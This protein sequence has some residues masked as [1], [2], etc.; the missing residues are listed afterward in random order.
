[1]PARRISAPRAGAAAAAAAAA[2]AIAATAAVRP[3]R[4]GRPG[5]PGRPGRA[6]K[7][8]GTPSTGATF[9]E[10]AAAFGAWLEA[11]AA[12]ATELLVG[13]HK[14]GTGRPSLTWSESVDEALCVGW[15]DGVR[16]RIDE[17]AYSIRF[18]PR[19]PGSI[20]S[21]I[22]TAK[23]EQLRAQGRM[24]PAGERAFAQRTVARSVVYA[25]EQDA[26]AGF[27]A[28]ELRAFRRDKAAWRFFEATPPGYR[29]VVTHWVTGAKKAQTRASRLA[30]LIE[31]SAAGQRLR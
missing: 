11:H 7:P 26:P 29:K 31:A 3:D 17:H 10:S 24:R 21:A 23:V 27:S 12:T 18:T 5:A 15:I 19:R 30:R 2:A 4:L 14:V 9:F 28:A 1:M 6:S 22:N 8:A 20:W 13:Y 25:Y 16:R